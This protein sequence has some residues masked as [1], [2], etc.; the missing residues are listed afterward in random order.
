MGANTLAAY[1][2]QAKAFAKDWLEQPAPDDM[3]EL[4][5]FHSGTQDLKAIVQLKSMLKLKFGASR[6]ETRR[7][8]YMQTNNHGF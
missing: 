6:Y 7:L 1:K 8:T 2:K 4:L 3:Y 5:T